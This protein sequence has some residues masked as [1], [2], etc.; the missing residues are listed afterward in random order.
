MLEQI[1]RLCQCGI[2]CPELRADVMSK[3]QLLL[4]VDWDIVNSEYNRGKLSGIK[5]FREMTG[6]HFTTIVSKNIVEEYMRIY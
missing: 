5:K 1:I 6:G 2:S 3:I 4:N